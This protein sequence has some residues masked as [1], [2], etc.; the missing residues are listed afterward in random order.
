MIPAHVKQLDEA[1]AAFGQPPG[2]EAIGGKGAGT[3]DVGTI[4]LQHVFRLA[5]SVGEFRHRALHAVGQLI[6]GDPGEDFRVVHLRI[7]ETVELAQVIE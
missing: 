1:D 5:A 7:A 2:Q 6:L 3:A 4:A